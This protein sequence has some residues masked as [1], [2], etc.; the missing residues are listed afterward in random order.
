MK[1][2]LVAITLLVA[3]C[4][5]YS[6]L[7]QQ[8]FESVH[9]AAR[10][11]RENVTGGVTIVKFR[12]LVGAYATEVSLAADKAHTETERTFVGFHEAALKSYRDSLQVWTVKLNQ[13]G[14]DLVTANT[15]ANSI[16][17]EKI[18]DDYSIVGKA[19]VPTLFRYSAD[20]LMQA[21][22]HRGAAKLDAADALY[23]GEPAPAVPNVT[24]KS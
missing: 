2:V 23:R 12:E 10:L 18:A 22:W 17:L 11:M 14:G 7:N 20:E 16:G 24:P 13:G 3:G 6:R 5:Q 8:K 1:R 21:A 4:S 15:N 19:L 9:R